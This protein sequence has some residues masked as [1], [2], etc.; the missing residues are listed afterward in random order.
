FAVFLGDGFDSRG[1]AQLLSADFLT[2]FQRRIRIE[3]AGNVC[4]R[5][6]PELSTGCTFDVS[7]LTR[8]QAWDTERL[9]VRLLAIGLPALRRIAVRIAQGNADVS[10]LHVAVDAKLP[11]S[12]LAF[13]ADDSFPAPKIVRRAL[14]ADDADT[15]TQRRGLVLAPCVMWDGDARAG[16]TGVLLHSAC[17]E[18][19]GIRLQAAQ[20]GAQPVDRLI[21]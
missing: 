5:V 7:G 2:G 10:V 18:H 16:E 9:Q 15:L 13:F 11:A 14:I 12:A 17:R 21:A 4:A 20:F 3:G 19:D 6:D 8:K 1:S